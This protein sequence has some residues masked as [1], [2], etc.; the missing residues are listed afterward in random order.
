MAAELPDFID[1]LVGIAQRGR[2]LGVHMILATQRP[3]GA[4]NDNIRANTNLR[5]S[6][7]VQEAAES[8]DIVGSPLAASIGRRQAGRGYVRLGASEVFPFQA[9]LVTGVTSKEEQTPV[10]VAR[11]VFGPDPIAADELPGGG[12][13]GHR[14]PDGA[15]DLEAP[16]GRRG[17]SGPPRRAG[18]SPAPLARDTARAGDAGRAGRCRPVDDRRRDRRR[19]RTL[20]PGR[21]PRPA[22][23]GS[24]LLVTDRSATCSSAA[25]PGPA[26]PTTLASVAVSLAKHLPAREAVDLRPRLRHP[27]PGRAWPGS[28]TAAGSS[29]PPT[30]SGSSGSSGSWPTN[31]SGAAATSPPRAR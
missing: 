12:H 18:R 29:A 7:R 22:A 3:G 15:S 30:G 11:F 2:S 5:I 6:L 4:V 25:W 8:S 20:R 19:R 9:A 24:V 17:R 31:W 10:R 14:R 23:A 28:P 27:G 16:G 21:R 26:P 1:S 13:G